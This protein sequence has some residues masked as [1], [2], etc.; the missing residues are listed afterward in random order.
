MIQY[1]TPMD[2]FKFTV[3]EVTV[4]PD[5][6]EFVIEPLQ[7]GYGHT[8]GNALRRVLYTS[9]PGAAITSVRINGV[10]HK[11][12][13]LKGLKENI[14]DLLL[15]LKEVIFRLSENKA[16]ATVKLSVK[17]ERQ[18]TANDLEVSDGIEVVNKDQY[19]GSLSGNAKLEMEMTV[20][21]GY[22]YSLAE[23][24]KADTL[25]VITTD[26]VFTP[27]R[28]VNYNIVATRVGRQT[29]LDKLVLKLW[30]NGTVSPRESLDMAAKILASYFSQLYKPKDEETADVTENKINTSAIPEKILKMT[31]DELDLP[32]RIY[33]SLRNG[34]IETLEQLINIPRKD[35]MSMRNMG[36]KSIS[37]IKERLAEKGVELSST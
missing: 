34:G 2:D 10:K 22:G 6:G 1:I 33:N 25:G 9:I 19:I 8:M 11:F 21:K 27:V 20:E 26:A 12:S 24:R 16:S 15:N 3:K 37:A 32:T 17:G 18:I 30:T 31:I 7:P 23:E 5:Y 4:S 36:S 28:R 35:L 14:I 29:N 13:T